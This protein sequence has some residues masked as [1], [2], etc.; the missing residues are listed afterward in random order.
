[1]YKCNYLTVSYTFEYCIFSVINLD[2]FERGFELRYSKYS[3]LIKK[4]KLYTWK[5]SAH[6]PSNH[7]VVRK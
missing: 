1:M 4:K 6:E 5:V 3:K 7:S 2:I